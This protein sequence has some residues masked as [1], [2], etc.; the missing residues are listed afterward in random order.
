MNADMS[1]MEV[2]EPLFERTIEKPRVL[3]EFFATWCGP[4]RI[5]DNRLAE[6]SQIEPNLTIV[7][8]NIEQCKHLTEKYR[9]VS[10]PTLIY[11]EQTDEINRHVGTIDIQG[12]QRLVKPSSINIDK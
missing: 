6:L 12:L 10:I 9:V 7:K 5:L 4:C 8:V 2:D 1:I 11:I 3:V